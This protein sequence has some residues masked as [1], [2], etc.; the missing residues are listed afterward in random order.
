MRRSLLLAL[1][2]AALLC[3][4]ALAATAAPGLLTLYVAPNGND[5]WSGRL[6]APDAAGT[7]GPFATLTAARDAIRHLK[8]ATTFNAPVKVLLRG[9]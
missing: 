4:Y 1:A 5:A 6:A 2:L 9:G 3:A 8:T 7:D